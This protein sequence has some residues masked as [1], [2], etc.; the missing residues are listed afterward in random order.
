MGDP[1]GLAGQAF[2]KIARDRLPRRKADR[3]DQAI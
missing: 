3:V 2:E 1:E